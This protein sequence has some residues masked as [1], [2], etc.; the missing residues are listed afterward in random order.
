MASKYV[1]GQDHS[2]H[3]V[4]SKT[5][6]VIYTGMCILNPFVDMV[7]CVGR[8]LYQEY[9]CTGTVFAIEYHFCVC[10][11]LVLCKFLYLDWSKCHK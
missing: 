4:C 10:S 7:I 8:S 1:N 9:M 11:I 2:W 3:E 5:Y 6:D